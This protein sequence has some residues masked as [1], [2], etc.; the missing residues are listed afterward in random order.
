MGDVDKSLNG[1]NEVTIVIVD[2]DL[3]FHGRPPV[4]VFLASTIN[5][6]GDCVK[7]HL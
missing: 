4:F 1:V 3:P 2:I 5:Q 7:V 6:H